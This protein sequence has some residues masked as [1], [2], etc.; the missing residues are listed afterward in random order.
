MTKAFI[1]LGMHKSGTTLVS[2]MLHQSGIAMV[3]DVDDRSYDQGNHFE[4]LSTNMLNKQL[5]KCGEIN[6]LRSSHPTG[7]KT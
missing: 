6:S 5:L 4:R 2:Q 3:S 7:R 1:I